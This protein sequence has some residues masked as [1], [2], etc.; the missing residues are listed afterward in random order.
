MMT[1]LLRIG[2][3]WAIAG[4][5]LALLSI[6]LGRLVA[7]GGPSLVLAVLIGALFASAMLRAAASVTATL[8]SGNDLAAR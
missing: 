4:L 6:P 2:F 8:W 5:F 3:V 1:L 7:G